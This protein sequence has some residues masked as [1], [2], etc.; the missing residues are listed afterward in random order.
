MS[1]K[2]CAV[3]KCKNTSIKTP[4][5]LF[6]CVPRNV[7]MRRKWLELSRRNCDEIMPSSNIFFC[8]DHFNLQ[9][10]MANYC[11]YKMGFSQRII[12]VDK[13]LP[14]KFSC[15]SDC[16][17]RI[18]DAGPSRKAFVKR[19]RKRL[20]QECEITIQ[21]PIITKNQRSAIIEPTLLKYLPTDTVEPTINNQ[22]VDEQY[23]LGL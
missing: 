12:M 5:K 18:S 20:I 17:K 8:E 6:I 7:K 4:E 11:E 16:N 22:P 14:S 19:Q 9:Q 2:W 15:Q 1:Y 10:D 21:Q 13:V 23:I 3:P